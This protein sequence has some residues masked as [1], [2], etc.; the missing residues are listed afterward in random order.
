MA[1]PEHDPNAIDWFNVVVLLGLPAAA[2]AGVA[3]YLPTH[4]L[5]WQEVVAAVLFW[6]L[7]GL[8]I[9]A[10][11]HRLF[12]HRTYKANR[13]V[14]FVMA[15]FGAAATQNS[16][17]SWASDHRRH[18]S[19]VD[20]ERD[21]YDARRGFWYS[22]MGWV[23]RKGYWAEDDLDNVPDLKKDPI[24]RH[25]HDHY[26]LWMLVTNLVM[27]GIAG[28]LTGRWAGM[29]VIAGLVRVV[30]VQHF[31]FFINSLAHLWGSQP[32]SAAN[33]SRNNP[34]L[35][36]LTLG[37]GYHNYHHAFETDYRNGIAWYAY[38]PT[39][40]L[41]FTMSKL[42]LSWDLRR[43]PEDVVLR[44]RF[45]EGR[46]TLTERLEAWGEA[47]A[48]A[49]ARNMS[50]RR[51]ELVARFETLVDQLKRDELD[52]DPAEELRE[53][54]QAR[55]AE[56]RAQMAD[57]AEELREQILEQ[58]RLAEE[59]LDEALKELRRQRQAWKR[60]AKA[61]AT[62]SSREMRLAARRE[63]RDLKQSW[64]EARQQAREAMEAW[65]DA[66]ALYREQFDGLASPA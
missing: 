21:P 5:G 44:R 60:S 11:Y 9:T 53:R 46:R 30:A 51:D 22:H 42:G 66:V 33:T 50:H 34:L 29:I 27:V 19:Y 57:Q 65:D 16:V 10:G 36:V 28:W 32:F 31:T 43:T 8:G 40:W 41:I 14:R 49:W 47:K 3:W 54:L 20:S 62:A 52:V 58:I 4:G 45:E 1:R 25:Q 6:H 63:M 64:N 24:L 18:H 55:A 15:A 56:L 37:E 12:S 48:E 2:V 59:A 39:K 7:A 35:S 13:A 61:R 38:D 17:L 23:F 26:L